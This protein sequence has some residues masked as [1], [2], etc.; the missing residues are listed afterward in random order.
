MTER[1]STPAGFADLIQLWTS[2][3]RQ[4]TEGPPGTAGL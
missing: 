4:I 3:L 1:H 2:Q